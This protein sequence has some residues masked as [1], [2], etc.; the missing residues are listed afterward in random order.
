VPT[1]AFHSNYWQ[2][3]APEPPG[4]PA[5]GDPSFARWQIVV[6]SSVLLCVF[7]AG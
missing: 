6:L 5:T 1:L 2:T 3:Q 7:L 4:D